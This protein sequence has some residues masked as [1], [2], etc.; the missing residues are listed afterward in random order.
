[1]LVQ[2]DTGDKDGDNSGTVTALRQSVGADH[3]F[4]KVLGESVGPC[5]SNHRLNFSF[6]L[7]F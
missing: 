1:V 3:T 5:V 2:R 7:L 6:C 4:L